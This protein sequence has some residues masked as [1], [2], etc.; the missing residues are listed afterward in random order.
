MADTVTT[1]T[2]TGY[3]KE[4]NKLPEV[5]DVIKRKYQERIGTCFDHDE[6]GY[7]IIHTDRPMT[8][9]I[10]ISECQ[11]QSVEI[12]DAGILMNGYMGV[13]LNTLILNTREA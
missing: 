3:Q 7:A 2:I 12:R 13:S 5:G 9:P 11:V 4:G 8:G 6:R 1:L 10:M